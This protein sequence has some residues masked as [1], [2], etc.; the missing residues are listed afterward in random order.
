ML[1]NIKSAW[2]IIIP[3]GA[4]VTIGS[5]VLFIGVLILKALVS[6]LVNKTIGE[7]NYKEI[8]SNA[9]EK[10]IETLKT[11]HFI[12]NIEPLAKSE[13]Q[14]V[15]EQANAM[16]KERADFF[17]SKWDKAVKVLKVFTEFFDNSVGVPESKKEELKAAFAE[18]ESKE[19][20]T[21]NI[22][23]ELVAEPTEKTPSALN[24]ETIE[25]VT[26]R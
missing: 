8:A 5:I 4:G 23:L 22:E 17:E 15:A 6:K 18:L 16:W 25:Q 2:D 1:E 9:T 12:Q 20:T 10:G 26:D 3:I 13:L 19:Q 24:N 11:M 14:K 7:I 21:E